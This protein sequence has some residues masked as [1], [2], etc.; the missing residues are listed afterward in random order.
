M[1]SDD[2]NVVQ[3]QDNRTIGQFNKSRLNQRKKPTHQLSSYTKVVG[4]GEH[5]EGF[6]A[7]AGQDTVFGQKSKELSGRLDDRVHV[8]TVAEVCKA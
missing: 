2:E 6:H 5:F 3:Y 1:T 7:R 8:V 4:S